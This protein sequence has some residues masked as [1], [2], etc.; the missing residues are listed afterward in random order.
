[1]RRRNEE[2]IELASVQPNIGAISCGTVEARESRMIR[3]F[4]NGCI[5]R[6][7]SNEIGLWSP[8]SK[9]AYWPSISV[10]AG[11]YA[12]L[13]WSIALLPWLSHA[14]ASAPACSSNSAAFSFPLRAACIRGVRPAGSTSFG[15]APAANSCCITRGWLWCAAGKG[16]GSLKTG[17]YLPDVKGNQ[18]DL[19]GTLLT[20]AGI[21]LDR[22]IGISEKQLTELVAS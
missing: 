13:T 12:G 10:K 20:C 9:V 5:S 15:L 3:G 4:S 7:G 2:E 1:M 19:L 21:P 17:R 16:G 18:G 11:I 14:D 22:Q 6:Q 8:G